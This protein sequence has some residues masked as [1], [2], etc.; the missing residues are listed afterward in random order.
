LL[1]ETVD[2]IVSPGIGGGKIQW[3]GIFWRAR[4]GF[5]MFVIAVESD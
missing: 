5:T 3:V 4:L 1:W 2:Q